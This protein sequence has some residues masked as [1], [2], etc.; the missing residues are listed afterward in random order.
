MASQQ[1]DAFQD[2]LDRIRRI[3]S[4][5]ET[6]EH[7]PMDSINFD[8][9]RAASAV[10][11]TLREISSQLRRYVDEGYLREERYI[12]RLIRQVESRAM[13]VRDSFPKG[14][15]MTMDET[16]PDLQ[17]PMERPLFI[18][19]K[20]TRREDRVLEAGSA[21]GGNLEVL[22]RQEHIDPNRLRQNIDALLKERPE[23][24]LQEVLERFPLQYGLMELL[25][26]LVLAGREEGEAFRENDWGEILFD[27]DGRKLRVRCERTVYRRKG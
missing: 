1:Q 21:P 4:L 27:H 26:Y 9:V 10:Q 8:W 24:T 2:L 16:A 17:F 22:V 11:E 12:H 14:V 15:V 6:L 3:A 25:G 19:A 23:V 13:A 5:Q 20:R 7:H 18:P